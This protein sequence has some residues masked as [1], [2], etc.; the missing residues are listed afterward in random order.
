MS[1]YKYLIAII[2]MIILSS[3]APEIQVNQEDLVR[4][5]YNGYK[6]AILNDR[7]NEAVKFLD[8]RTI[9]YYADILETVKTADSA[10]VRSLNIIDRLMVLIIRHKAPHDEILK[11]DGKSLLVYA[12]K[13]GMIAKNSVAENTISD[14]VIV[15]KFAKADFIS[16]GQKSELY[17]HFY[18]EDGL[19]KLNLTSNFPIIAVAFNKIIED[20]GREENEF[21]LMLVEVTSGKKPGNEIWHPIN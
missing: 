5:T 12:I 11:F 17:F 1:Q 8:K 16:K 21:L 6:T 20:S 14:I 4:K 18:K 19:W 9:K 15:N 2:A 13:E 7:G 3:C 10:A